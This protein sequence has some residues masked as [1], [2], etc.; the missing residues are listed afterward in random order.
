MKSIRSHAFRLAV[1]SLVATGAALFAQ[2]AQAD[3][4]GNPTANC[5]TTLECSSGQAV[6]KASSRTRMDTTIDTGWYPKC[7]GG[8][9][10]CS[11][12]HLQVRADI[13]LDAPQDQALFEIDMQKG[14]IVDVTWPDKD[15]LTL[16]LKNG[17]RTDGKLT[18]NH[19]LIPNVS[20]YVNAFDLF[21]HEFSYDATALIA[22]IPSANFN[23][24]ASGSATF[25]PWGLDGT[26]QATVNGPDLSN[27]ELFSIDIQENLVDGTVALSVTANPTFAYK[28]TSVQFSGVQNALSTASPTGKI[29]TQ[30][31]D[32]VDLIAEVHGE[33]TFKGTMRILP[34]VRIT[35]AGQYDLSSNPLT[36]PVD[37]GLDYD[38]T[39][40]KAPVAVVFTKQTVHVPLPNVFVTAEAVNFGEIKTGT[41]AEQSVAVNNT[42]ELGAILSIESS[43]P[44][45][46]ISGPQTQMDKKSKKD[47]VVR[48]QP[49]TDG[50]AK[51]TITVKSNDPDSPVQTF[52]VSGRSSPNAKPGNADSSGDPSP[53]VKPGENSGCGCRVTSPNAANTAGGALLAM[54]ALAFVRRRRS[55]K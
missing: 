29:K 41:A 55:S 27:S 15:A 49:R 20:L 1:S 51:A 21:K 30:N 23:Y 37:V 47:I 44:Q 4:T 28:T 32:Y 33:V 16:K 2:P 10:H 6:L 26:A 14:A 34:N 54:A 31:A 40:E 35:R 9:D 53:D 25:A 3:T 8:H 12:H 13:A 7:D 39:N 17:A 48:Y 11:D 22:K 45:F 38:F 5:Q 46:V 18:V 42:G 43:D 50:D 52:T 36:I 19:T 24:L